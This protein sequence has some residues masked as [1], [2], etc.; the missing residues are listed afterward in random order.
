MA[1]VFLHRHRV[2]YAECT[3]GNHVYYSRY[4][5][6]LESARASSSATLASRLANFRRKT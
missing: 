3:V 2:T 6:L 4:L 1:D 5:D